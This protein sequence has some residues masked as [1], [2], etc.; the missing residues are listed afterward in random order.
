MKQV[1]K[2]SKLVVYVCIFAMLFGSCKGV[3]KLPE[4]MTIPAV[5]AFGDSI[6]DQGNNNLIKTLI[7][8][9]FPPYGQ[10][11]HGGFASG[12][13]TNGKTPP[14]L[15]GNYFPTIIF[16]HFSSF[17]QTINFECGE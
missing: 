2:C 11:F 3:I 5:Y 14:D 9:N 15:I 13:F 6:V 1:K 12:R 10:D 16:F 17:S 4:N 8:C 7:Y